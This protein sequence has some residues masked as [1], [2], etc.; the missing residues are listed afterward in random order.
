MSEMPYFGRNP[1][2]LGTLAVFVALQPAI[3]HAKN[4]QALLAIRFLS[5]LFGSPVLATGGASIVDMYQPSKRA[6]T[7][8]IWGIAAIM[9]PVMDPMVGG[10]TVDA[11]GWKWTI[12]EILWLSGF[13]FVFLFCFLPETSASH[14]IFARTSRLRKIIGD[15][16]PAIK[17]Q[18]ELEGES[19]TTREILLMLFIRPF[20]LSFFEPIVLALNFYIALLYALMYLWFESFPLVFEGIYGFNGG[21]MG[22]AYL[23]ILVGC[24]LTVPPFWW[25]LRRV[26]EPRFINGRLEP[27][28]RV[29]PAC[30]CGFFIP[31][32][33][34][35]FGWSSRSSVHWIVPTIGTIFFTPGAFL[36]FNSVLNYLGGAY[37]LHAASVYAGNDLMRSSFGAGFPLFAPAMFHRL[38]VAWASTLLEFLSIVFI[39]VPFVLV[40]YGERLRALS[41][42]ARHDI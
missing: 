5:G 10:F 3:I 14:I 2:Y 35:W 28:H 9:G 41:R 1:V 31:I 29:P 37:P 33:L 12:W 20:T 4:F 8:S 7:I 18:P 19:L 39:P 25:Y 42:H 22:L 16:S 40:R 13:C 38:G 27:E 26:T 34:F 36:L 17:C 23:G 11:K 21:E 30:V 24:L 6:Y 32:S 15:Q